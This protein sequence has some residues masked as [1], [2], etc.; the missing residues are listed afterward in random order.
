MNKPETIVIRLS[1]ETREAWERGAGRLPISTWVR[2]V[3]AA[4]LHRSDLLDQEQEPT[5]AAGRRLAAL[6]APR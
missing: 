6:R 1:A 5:R 2:R 4:H 3:V